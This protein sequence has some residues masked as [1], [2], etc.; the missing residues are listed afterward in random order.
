[1]KI[2]SGTVLSTLTLCVAL[3]SITYAQPAVEFQQEDQQN[4][5]LLPS[6]IAKPP[7]PPVADARKLYLEKQKKLED[8]AQGEWHQS[9]ER[10]N[11]LRETRLLATKLQEPRDRIRAAVAEAFDARRQLQQAE[12]AE[13][14][15]RIARIKRALE[16]RDAMR[17]TVI[18]QRTDELLDQMEERG[19]NGQREGTGHKYPGTPDGAVVPPPE[20]DAR[21]SEGDRRLNELDAELAADVAASEVARAH[22]ALEYAKRMHSKG[23]VTAND[24]ESKTSELRR[25]TLKLD[26]ANRLAELDLQEAKAAYG[27]AKKALSRV[28]KLHSTG[29]VAQ[30]VYDEAEDKYNRAKIQLERARVKFESL[31]PPAKSD[32]PP[33]DG[34]T[35]SPDRGQVDK[36]QIVWCEPVGSLQL[37]MDFEPR[38]DSYQ[39]GD[40]LTFGLIVRNSGD[41][42]VEFN[43]PEPQILERLGLDLTLDDGKGGELPWTWGSAHKKLEESAP[44]RI[45][46]V[47]LGPGGAH[48]LPPVKI[49][50]GR[51]KVLGRANYEPTV[52]AYLD[53]T[54]GQTAYLSFKLS[55][56]GAADEK[57]VELR[58]VPFEF[59][60]EEPGAKR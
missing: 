28:E 10:L 35:T 34:A 37:G 58:S 40:V 60:V 20:S 16:I 51:R 33:A 52:F 39:L 25:A 30:E 6:T 19:K 54:P 8:I 23:F 18:D 24:V 44:S 3:I 47:E 2:L 48:E 27:A 9:V 36:P 13:L 26:R 5:A 42:L 1:M 59:S 29:A 21:K 31:A 17:D 55:W 38:K 50:V 15:N 11:V 41:K 53:V 14:E 56:V 46:P 32:D 7:V 12:L 4:G 22:H 45:I 49:Q 57:T 43:L